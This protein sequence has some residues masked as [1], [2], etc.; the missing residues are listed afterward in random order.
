MMIFLHDAAGHVKFS[1][2]LLHEKRPHAGAFSFWI[3]GGGSDFA[4]N[5][6]RD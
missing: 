5:F 6:G 4:A 2:F 3:H 1:A